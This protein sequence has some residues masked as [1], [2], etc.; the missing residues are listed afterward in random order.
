[1][2]Q[3]ALVGSGSPIIT[4]VDTTNIE[5]HT[6][7]LSERDLAQIEPGQP[8]EITFKAYPNQPVEGVVSRI[9]PQAGE[10]LGDAATFPVVISLNETDLD[11]LIGMTGRIEILPE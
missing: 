11:L 1:V 10:P 6:T 3:G 4:L 2:A 8:V 7:N 5:F 9:A